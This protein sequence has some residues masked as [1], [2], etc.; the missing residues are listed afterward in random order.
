VRR[1][2][3]EQAAHL[4][5]RGEWDDALSLADEYLSAVEAGSPHQMEG[6]MRI[7]RGRIR[8]ARG[9]RIGA[10]A[11]AERALEF[12]RHTGHP[13]DVLATLAFA[14]RAALTRDGGRAEGLADELLTRLAAEHSL[15]A[16][17]ALPDAVAVATTLGRAGE[18]AGI[19]A[20]V[21]EPTAWDKAALA[22][23]RGDT[24]AAAAVYHAMGAL[25]EEAETGE[26]QS[27][28]RSVGAQA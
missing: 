16:A 20:N 7:L 5:W 15:W 25:P 6:D 12:G 10:E 8:L 14:A 28:W 22:H 27:F 18:L 2:R 17:W 3:A 9:D 19:L 11:D 4:Y 26:G 13:F 23:A 24:A 1:F 21:A